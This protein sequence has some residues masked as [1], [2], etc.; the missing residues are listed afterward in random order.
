MDTDLSTTSFLEVKM[1][2]PPGDEGFDISHKEGEHKVFED[3]AQGIA[4]LTG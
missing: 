1:G 2:L 3:L 4:N